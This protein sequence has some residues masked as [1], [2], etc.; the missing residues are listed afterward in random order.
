VDSTYPPPQAKRKVWIPV[1]YREPQ[2]KVG[3]LVR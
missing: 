1:L 2:L 3:Q